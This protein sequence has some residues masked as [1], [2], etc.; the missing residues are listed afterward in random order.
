MYSV[1]SLVEVLYC[2]KTSVLT[3]P[4]RAEGTSGNLVPQLTTLLAAELLA[5][6]TSKEPLVLVHILFIL[7]HLDDVRKRVGTAIGAV[8]AQGAVVADLV[9]DTSNGLLGARIGELSRLPLSMVNTALLLPLLLLLL[10]VLLVLE[11][12]LLPLLLGLRLRLGQSGLLLMHAGEEADVLLGLLLDGA[13]VDKV[14]VLGV[15]ALGEEEG[16]EARVAH[17][18]IHVAEASSPAIVEANPGVAEDLAVVAAHGLR[19]ADAGNGAGRQASLL[20]EEIILVA[21][22]R[23]GLVV[24]S[25]VERN[26]GVGRARHGRCDARGRHLR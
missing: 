4:A 24:L 11:H 14:V 19:H 9:D 7:L 2:K 25:L 12:L 1:K 26:D 20:L 15:L 17:V 18:H 10:L 22:L 23:R 13:G 16:G 21:R 8:G 5:L 3:L 6:I